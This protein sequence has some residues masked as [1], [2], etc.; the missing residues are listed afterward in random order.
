[1][2][3]CSPSAKDEVKCFDDKD[4]LKIIQIY[5]KHVEKKIS[6]KTKNKYNAINSK[7]KDILGNKNHFLWIDYISQYCSYTDSKIL[8]NIADKRLMPKKP[9]EWY[10][11]KTAWLS[12]FDI[13]NV[14]EHYHRTKKFKYE[15]VGVFT[16]DF[17]LKNEDG[18]CKFYRNKCVPD[19][20]KN[21]KDG[22]KYLGIVTNLDRN[23]QS[24]SHWTSIFI[25]IDKDLPSYGIYYYDSVGSGIPSLIMIYLRETQKQL[26][27]LNGKQCRIK[28]NKKQFQ[29]SNTECGMFSITYQIS[30]LNKLLKNKNTIERDILDEKI[31]NDET[32]I[33]YR[34][35]YF[36]PRLVEK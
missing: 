5:N 34:D 18:S 29:H 20:P 22:K 32:M 4:L 33:T 10:L 16:V 26:Y 35:K 17:A 8:E 6:E 21:I 7:L 14:L 30:W 2:S 9:S 31:M 1:M 19:I 11:N 13:E 25:V 24:G 3:F 27:K 12:N 36:A 15:F 28:S 23:D